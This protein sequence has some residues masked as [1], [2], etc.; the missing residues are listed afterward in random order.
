MFSKNN[1]ILIKAFSHMFVPKLFYAAV[2]DGVASG[3][4]NKIIKQTEY[5]EYSASTQKRSI[6]NLWLMC[7]TLG[8]CSPIGGA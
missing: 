5:E 8:L 3:I 1:E 7:R 6:Q 2:I 4:I